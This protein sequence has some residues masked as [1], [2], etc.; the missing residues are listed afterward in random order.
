MA[1]PEIEWW[2]IPRCWPGETIAIIG[3]GKSLTDEQIERCRGRCRVV[4]I[5]RAYVRAPWAD[6]LWGCDPG[7]FWA[8]C[9]R[10]GPERINHDE[11]DP[12][13]F[14]GTKIAVW[15]P[16]LAGPHEQYIPTLVAE[17]VKVIRHGGAEEECH[18]G[19]SDDPG[20]VKG[21]N[22][23][24]QLISALHHTGCE[25]IILLG[26]DMRN[27]RA[28]D[29]RIDHRAETHWHARWP[30]SDPDFAGIVIPRLRTMAEPLRARRVEVIN[31]SPGSA[32]DAF[33]RARLEDVLP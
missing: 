21:D 13:D 22:S 15:C 24:S 27:E 7:R 2:S 16:G 29:G 19:I 10:I 18:T 12:L 26:I 5:N 8:W 32:L 14:A 1:P 23:C 4:A 6:W 20:L 31:C 3:G 17:G 28:A 11:P 30:T 25:C 9:S 33:P